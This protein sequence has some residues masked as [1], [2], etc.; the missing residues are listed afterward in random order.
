MNID[1]EKIETQKR[2]FVRNEGGF[3]LRKTSSTSNTVHTQLRARRNLSRRPDVWQ[4]LRR[5]FLAET[6]VSKEASLEDNIVTLFIELAVINL[7]LEPVYA[8]YTMWVVAWLTI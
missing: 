8:I 2:Y 1:L 3:I 6:S 7:N 5:A 4:D